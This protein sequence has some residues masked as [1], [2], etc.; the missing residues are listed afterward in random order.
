MQAGEQCLFQSLFCQ[1][2]LGRVQGRGQG[3]ISKAGVFPFL[4]LDRE[5]WKKKPVLPWPS[6]S[7]ELIFLPLAGSAPGVDEQATHAGQ[8]TVR[9]PSL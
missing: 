3:S 4:W 2:P 5:K 9:V 6:A 8:G 1:D 7:L